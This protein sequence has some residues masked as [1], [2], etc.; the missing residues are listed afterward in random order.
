[1]AQFRS[2]SRAGFNDTLDVNCD[3]FRRCAPENPTT[4]PGAI[5]RQPAPQN[6]NCEKKSD[7]LI[8]LAIGLLYWHA[9]NSK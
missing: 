4:Q 6:C 2:R 8:W 7:F 1:M 9:L 5:E 3:F